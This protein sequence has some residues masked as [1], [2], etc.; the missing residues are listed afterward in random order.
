[1]LLFLSLAVGEVRE[2]KKSRV[3]S[4]S[5]RRIVLQFFSS[6]RSDDHTEFE[7]R[8]SAS[9]LIVEVS[10]ETSPILPSGF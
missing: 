6:S 7:V 10:P 9:L 1:M 5:L 2:E 4:A 3:C 8:L